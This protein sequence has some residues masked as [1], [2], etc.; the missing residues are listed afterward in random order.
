[1][2]HPKSH[3]MI[4]ATD[5]GGNQFL[6]RGDLVK[7]D[8]VGGAR[9]DI[10]DSWGLIHDPL[11]AVISPCDIRIGPYKGNG[12]KAV[13]ED[14]VLARI[15]Q[16]YFGHGMDVHGGSVEVPDGTW[17]P[18]GRVEVVY[19]ARYGRGNFD[20]LFRHPIKMQAPAV[21]LL[22][23]RGGGGFKLAFPQGCIIDSH[24]FV[25]P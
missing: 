1:M 22:K 3:R 5:S 16:A 11:G 23:L 14:P 25:W 8:L 2:G 9:Q 12:H 20:G 15:A 13:I 4:V 24:G 19:Y 21:N 6:V 17:E 7:F 18:V 10:P